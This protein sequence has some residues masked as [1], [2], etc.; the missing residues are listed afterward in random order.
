VGQ[1]SGLVLGNVFKYTMAN[2]IYCKKLDS[3]SYTLIDS[4][5]SMAKWAKN[6]LNYQ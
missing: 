2:I 3:F 6:V 4:M 5:G 1:F